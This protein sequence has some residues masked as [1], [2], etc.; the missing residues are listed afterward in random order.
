[1]QVKIVKENLMLQFQERFQVLFSDDEFDFRADAK[2]ITQ[3]IASLSYEH[4]ET[5]DSILR[6]D[7]VSQA[8]YFIY[9]GQVEVSYK[10][11]DQ[12]ILVY[13]QGSYIGD[14]SYIFQIRNQYKYR[15]APVK[16]GMKS[17]FRIYSLQDRY[18]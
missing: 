5:K 17:N 13:D 18:L 14:A 6:L 9:D 8:L 10:Q 3:I 11:S 16:S 7:V 12:V 2:L 4:F 1:M 15:Q